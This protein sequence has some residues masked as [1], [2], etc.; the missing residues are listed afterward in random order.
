MQMD[1]RL[2]LPH[3]SV[4]SIAWL[5]WEALRRAGFEGCVF[6]KVCSGH[7]TVVNASHI[8]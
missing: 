2:A 5:D 8:H 7:E 6:D 3:V 1:N 4:P